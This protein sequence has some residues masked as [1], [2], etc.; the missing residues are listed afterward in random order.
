MDNITAKLLLLE[1]YEITYQIY[2]HNLGNHPFNLVLHHYKESVEDYSPMQ[3]LLRAYVAKGVY[4]RF[5]ISLVEFLNLPR[6]VNRNLL[7]ICDEFLLRDS[8][9]LD[10]ISSDLE[11]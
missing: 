8:Q 2:N 4:K 6:H 9:T 5:G 11:T 10:S 3:H 7:R 1:A